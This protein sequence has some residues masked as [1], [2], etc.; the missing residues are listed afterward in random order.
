MLKILRSEEAR[1]N[2]IILLSWLFFM[3]LIAV[4]LFS[5][6]AIWAIAMFALVLLCMLASA[7]ISRKSEELKDLARDE[8]TEKFS[9]K[10][11]RNG[12]L[13]AVMLVTILTALTWLHGSWLGTLDILIWIWLW[14]TGTYQLSYLYYVMRG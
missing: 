5:E 6:Y 3:P 1:I 8:R 11:S 10:A 4:R 13:M 14:V 2:A 7:L 12:L 9:M